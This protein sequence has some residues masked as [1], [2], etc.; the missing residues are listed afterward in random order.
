MYHYPRT[1][2]AAQSVEVPVEIWRATRPQHACDYTPPRPVHE[3]LDELQS[4]RSGCACDYECRHM[5][6]IATRCGDGDT[7]NVGGRGGGVVVVVGDDH[8]GVGGN[9]VVDVLRRRY[10]RR[11]AADA[12]AVVRTRRCDRR[13]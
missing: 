12:A 10:E 6:G 11:K 3:L 2:V 8:V 7:W 1:V 5:I 13:E 4:H 9:A